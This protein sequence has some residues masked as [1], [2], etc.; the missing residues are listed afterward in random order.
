MELLLPVV[1]LVELVR[2]V[3]P[4]LPNHV[5]ILTLRYSI[6]KRYRFPL[7]YLSVQLWTV[8]IWVTGWQLPV[9]YAHWWAT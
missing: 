5:I 6:G 7:E 2:P 8:R 9:I 1:D 3:E 4:A